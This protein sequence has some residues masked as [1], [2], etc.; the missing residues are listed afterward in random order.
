MRAFGG[1]SLYAVSTYP[2]SDHLFTPTV[3]EPDM[4]ILLS[5]RRR[6]FADEKGAEVTELGIVLAIVVAGAVA[7]LKTL[8]PLVVAAYDSINNAL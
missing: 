4:R 8:G 2:A 3:K 1:S 6:F 5:L 7:A